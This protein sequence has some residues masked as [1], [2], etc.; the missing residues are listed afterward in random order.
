MASRLVDLVSRP[1]TERDVDAVLVHLA[2]PVEP[3]QLG[4]S[5][6]FF[7]L[8]TPLT[9]L[10]D[11]DAALGTVLDKYPRVD[12]SD[13][14]LVNVLISRGARL[15][16]V[17]RRVYDR[18]LEH[19]EVD[20]E[21]DENTSDEDEEARESFEETVTN[22]LLELNRTRF[23]ASVDLTPE[24]AG[25]V[26]LS[27]LT[28]SEDEPRLLGSHRQSRPPPIEA[29]HDST[30]VAT[31]RIRRAAAATSQ[32]HRANDDPSTDLIPL[33]TALP[34]R[35]SPE[36]VSTYFS[37]TVQVP[38]EIV[39]IVVDRQP[40]H[41]I[42]LVDRSTFESGRLEQQIRRAVRELRRPFVD[43]DGHEWSIRVRKA[44]GMQQ[45][46]Q[47]RRRVEAAGAQRRHRDETPRR[48]SSSFNHDDDR[49]ASRDE[50]RRIR[51]RSRRRG[52][53]SEDDDRNERRARKQ[54]FRDGEEREWDNERHASE[55]R[56]RD[57]SKTGE[58]R[59]WNS[60]G[61][62]E[63]FVGLE[64]TSLRKHRVSFR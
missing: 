13:V 12:A 3:A 59:G 5:S 61:G 36:A 49:G 42:F 19:L 34:S 24:A 25:S 39:Q 44:R 53:V 6:P 54:R 63:E 31:I 60:R 11:A 41:A 9:F 45:W 14:K 22:K 20:T 57:Q 46:I 21:E 29:Q 18:M 30:S 7:L 48:Q 16:R 58:D 43:R 15:D 55:T 8:E 52:R 10:S 62:Y 32:G 23:Y 56:F 1:C 40:A 50:E 38:I 4:E 33:F 35:T 26:E 51:Q 64:A 17:D 47:D 28:P 37:Q 27:P 2:T